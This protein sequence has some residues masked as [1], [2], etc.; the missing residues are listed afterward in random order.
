MKRLALI[1]F[2]IMPTVTFAQDQ[3]LFDTALGECARYITAK[4]QSAWTFQTPPA[5]L[6]ESETGTNATIVYPVGSAGNFDM[7]VGFDYSKGTSTTPG[8]WTC[9]G[10]GPAAPLWPAFNA[11]GWIGAD[12]RLR[13]NGLFELNFPGPQRAYA[14]CAAEAP[15][16]YVLFNAGDGDRAVFVAT[17]GPTAAAFCTS[18]GWKG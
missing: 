14:N 16:V 13:G 12:A 10:T 9:S 6:D 18:M 4:P 17:T 8:T 7:A 5:T 11:T 1:T 2:L 3:A 15:D